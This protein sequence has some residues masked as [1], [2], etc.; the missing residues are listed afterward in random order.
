MHAMFDVPCPPEPVPLS[1]SDAFVAALAHAGT[2]PL[3][4]ADGTVVLHRKF[5]PLPLHMITRPPAQTPEGM[6]MAARAVPAKG[7]LILSPDRPMP[8]H[9]IGAVPLVSPQSIAVLDLSPD[10]AQLQAN[11]HHKWRNRLKHAQKQT[12]RVARQNMPDDP[13][14]WLL[15]ADAAQQRSRGYRGW[16]RALTLAYARANPGQAKLFT[17]FCG[18]EPVAGVV[19]LRYGCAATY[20]IGHTRPSGRLLSAH[21]LL[22]WSA[23]RWARSQGLHQLELGTIDTE[24][25]SG[26]ARFKLGTGAGTRALGGTWAWWPPVTRLLRPIARLDRGLMRNG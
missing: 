6:L 23:I 8:L 26:L 5:G 17:A 16:P 19:L 20:H 1:Q 12:L 18:R 4:L 11:L 7:P 24:D 22:M 13:D 25:G 15:N 14:H 3:R 10:P 21:T 2:P 9:E